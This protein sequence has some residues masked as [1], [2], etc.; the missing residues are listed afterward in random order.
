MRGTPKAG[1]MQAYVG[2]DVCEKEEIRRL[3][4]R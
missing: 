4:A 1:N 2:N 3:H